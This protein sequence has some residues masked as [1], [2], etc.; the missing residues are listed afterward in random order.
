MT[1]SILGPAISYIF[2]RIEHTSAYYVSTN[3][4]IVLKKTMDR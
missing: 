1:F 3:L 2:S 4:A